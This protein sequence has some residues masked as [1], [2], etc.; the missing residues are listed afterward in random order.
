M[1][2]TGCLLITMSIVVTTMTVPTESVHYA[3]LKLSLFSKRWISYL[4]KLKYI[5][6]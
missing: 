5:P 2:T 4:Y 1:N 6:D 3:L